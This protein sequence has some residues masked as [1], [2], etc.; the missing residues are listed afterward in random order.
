MTDFR[1]CLAFVLKWEGGDKIT[2]DPRDPG[3]T[4]KYGIS[5]RAHPSLDIESLTEAQAAAIYE[6]EY[7]RPTGCDGLAWPLNLCAF[8]CA[9][10]QGPGFAREALRLSHVPGTVLQIRWERYQRSK[11]FETYGRG[12]GNRLRDLAKVGGVLWEPPQ[13]QGA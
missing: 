3:G 6:I 13:K 9:V 8:D 1:R 12:W 11:G 2:R 7:W 4:T 5:Q 10:N